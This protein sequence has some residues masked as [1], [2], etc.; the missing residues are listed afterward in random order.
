MQRRL[1][2]VLTV[3]GVLWA[4]AIVLVP[5]GVH[6]GRAPLA[7]AAAYTAASLVCHQ[8]IDRS[9]HLCGVPWLVCARCA[10]LYFAAAA[11]A[12]FAW[13]GPPRPARSVRTMLLAAALPTAVTIALEWPGVADPGN[14]ARALAALPL[15]AASAWVCLRALRAEADAVRCD[16]I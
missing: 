12:A 3:A 8:Q 4:L 6:H 7:T 11:A 5:V 13:L 2:L 16:I 10:G 9:F 1:A 15:G 14:T